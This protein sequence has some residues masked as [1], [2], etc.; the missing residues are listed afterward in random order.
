M[1]KNLRLWEFFKKKSIEGQLCVI[2]ER[3]MQI[4]LCAVTLGTKND[5]VGSNYLPMVKNLGYDYV[6]LPL[7]QMMELSNA[8]FSQIL[9]VLRDLTLPCGAL[10]NFLPAD[11]RIVGNHIDQSR[12]SEYLK[13]ALERAAWLGAKRLVFGSAGARNVEEG[14]SPEDA[15]KQIKNFL[16]IASEAVK[17]YD[18][19]IAIEPIHHGESNIINRTRDGTRLMREVGLSNVRMLID[20]YHY[21]VEHDGGADILQMKGDIRHAHISQPK[22]RVFPTYMEIDEYSSFIKLLKTAD[23]DERI[24]VEGYSAFPSRDAEE[25]LALLR[26]IDKKVRKE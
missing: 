4:G 20:Y 26:D 8:D 15:W 3:F 9:N 13:K 12:I 7:A 18:I 14:E 22:G 11:L 10:N 5:P 25:A 6:E 17:P 1:H 2:G 16:Y 23:Y 24:S 19:T 21:T